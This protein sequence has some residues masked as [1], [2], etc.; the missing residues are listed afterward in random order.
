MIPFQGLQLFDCRRVGAVQ[1]EN[2]LEGL[3][4]RRQLVAVLIV[5]LAQVIR[6]FRNGNDRGDL[7]LDG[8]AFGALL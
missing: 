6:A 7:N 2:K 8:N 1:H 5:D 4:A 3:S